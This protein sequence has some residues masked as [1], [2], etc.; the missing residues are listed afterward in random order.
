MTYCMLEGKERLPYD[1]MRTKNRLKI[2]AGGL[3]LIS[4]STSGNISVQVDE[5][6]LKCI[7]VDMNKN[8]RHHI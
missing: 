5:N 3:T 8:K 1:M 4:L 7:Q 2:M 6:T